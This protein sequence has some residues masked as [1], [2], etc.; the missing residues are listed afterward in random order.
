M[1]KTA[2]VRQRDVLGDARKV[3]D[4][5]HWVIEL[6]SKGGAKLDTRRQIATRRP[7]CVCWPT[8]GIGAG[9]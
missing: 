6:H 4:L 7:G 1:D 2:P 9:T 5:T 3:R 8:D